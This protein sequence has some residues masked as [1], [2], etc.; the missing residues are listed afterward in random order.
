M[1]NAAARIAEEDL[2]SLSEEQRRILADQAEVD[3]DE[4][5]DPELLAVLHESDEQMARGE[6]VDADVVLAEVDAILFGS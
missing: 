4:P 6:V 5:L 2:D 1:T 3:L